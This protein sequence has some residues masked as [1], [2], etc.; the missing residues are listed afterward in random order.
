MKR[1][2][3]AFLIL[4]CLC[5]IYAQNARVKISASPVRIGELL[6]QIESQTE[7]LFVYNKKN[8]DVR[9]TVNIS[10]DSKTT[11]EILD[12]AFRGTDIG[13]VTEGN[14]IVLTRS[15]EH[16]TTQQN[17][18]TVKGL[19]TDMKGD[20]IIG[21]NI[22]QQG[23]G[24][25]TITN[26]SGHFNIDIDG[27][28]SLLVSYMGYKS[29][30]VPVN[31]RTQLTIRLEEEALA[32]ETVVI[33]AMGIERK[34]ASLTYATQ[35]VE[36]NELVR[37]KDPNMINSLAGKTSGVLINRSSSGIGGS[38]KVNIRGSRSI[39][40]NNQ[41]LYV[42]DGVPMLNNSNEQVYTILGGLADAGNRDSGDGISN[43]NPEDIE[44]I[45]I[46]KGASAAALYGSQAANGVV[47]ITT[48]K[49]KAGVQR[50]TFSSTMTFD[51]A[52]SLPKFQNNYG[53]DANKRSWGEKKNLTDY[54]NV[55]NFFRTG[56]TAVNSF[57]FTKG[58]ETLQTYFSYANTYG[59]GIVEGNSLNKH[60]IN[61]RQTASFFNERLTLDG[62]VNLMQ[63]TLKNRPTPGGYYMNPL[64]GL[65]SF[66]RGENLGE[67]QTN[68]ET[69][70][71]SRNMNVQHWY[72]D[73]DAFEQNPYWITNRILS[74]DQRYRTIGNLSANLKI[75]NWLTL[76]A[77]GTADYISDK[78]TQKMYASTAPEIAGI[79][80]PEGS[81]VG[82][83]NGRY[84]NLDHSELLL[85][86]DVMAMFSN[87]WNDWTLSG[88][89]G[90]SINSTR[91]N[92][93]RLDSKLASLY[94]PNVFTVSN[95]VMNT[96]AYID[97]K[98][99]ERRQLQSIFGTAQLGWR[100]SVYLD[101][102]ARNDWSS[103]L[104]FTEHSSFF[105]P[106]VG[107]SWIINNTLRL[108]SWISFGKVRS[109]WS[110]VGNDLP[111]FYSRLQDK[112]I[113]G[114]GILSNDRA[115]FD[116][117][118][119]ELSSSFE[120][121]AE[122]KFF[123]HRL[124]FDFTFYQTD[125]KNQL[126]TLPST[127]GALYKYYMVNAG[128]IRNKGVEI[129]VGATPVITNDFRWKTSMNYSSN[130]NTVVELHPDLSSFVYGEEGFSMN[131]AM[132]LKEGGSLG[133]IYGWKFDR[134]EN[135]TIK[136][137]DKGLP[138]SIGSG[139]TEKV[140]N[141]NPDYILGW[142]NTL[143]Y[144]RFSLYFL[145]D[146]RVGGDV[147]SQTQAEL[148]YRGVS[149]NSGKARDKG[150]I[151]YGGQRFEDIAAFYSHIG[152]RNSTITEYYMYSAT[153][154]RLRELSLAYS[155]PRTML[156]KT[157]VFQSIDLS[158]IGRNLFFFHK[159]APFDP[160]TTMSTD[161]SCQGVDVFGMPT[162]R[163]IGFNVKFTF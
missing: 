98:I 115:P 48:K 111:L 82:Y 149:A 123:N 161:N 55:D 74:K 54:N 114:G 67:Y 116:K 89:I 158:L 134:D 24:S 38:V 113:A 3:I 13:Y 65:Y 153:N 91:V 132:R 14:N 69:F 118:K 83:A 151:E 84:I 63:Q 8:V 112:I 121:G 156:E 77:R 16:T 119:P 10:T 150:Y 53:M 26:A 57:S 88:A 104:A 43:L 4:A 117:L 60:N 139:N 79:Y 37:A 5:P 160:D 103:T 17:F 124:D 81:T 126:L 145:I 23:S 108:P 2:L 86:G 47:L 71:N 127:A 120:V 56:L 33:T 140:G 46:L 154:V 131:Y 12:E 29:Q 129:T 28:V 130:K 97:E 30:I 122:L 66:P 152:A 73:I 107:L 105:Y 32:L 6:E 144:K 155:F 58:S 110:Q 51:Q 146:A 99:N 41:P 34:E 35:L 100:E 147:L 75:T 125:T 49:G 64:V 62:N 76:Q 157:K 42:I 78:Y 31:G 163:S 106:S 93:L 70:D 68:F 138:L 143:S 40:G 136:L 27:D 148:D 80:I 162:T 9:R 94:Y 101:V 92:S 20:P 36:G 141:S 19:V 72:K 15:I 87:T 61:F 142:S 39:N 133:D 96:K 50:A 109:S 11:S 44:Y 90:S 95:I 102:T 7:Y 25:G 128:K 22:I 59:K 18:V 159:D 1:Y 45:N 137:N 85:Y 135:G 52:I 21:A